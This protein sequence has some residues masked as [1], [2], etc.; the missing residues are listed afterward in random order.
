[1]PAHLDHEIGLD[2]LL[3]WRVIMSFAMDIGTRDSYG[4]ATGGKEPGRR[5]RV[6]C[7]HHSQRAASQRGHTYARSGSRDLPVHPRQLCAA[8][9]AAW[10]LLLLLSDK[11]VQGER[12][13][14]AAPVPERVLAR[15][16]R[17]AHVEVHV[18]SGGVDPR[19]YAVRKLV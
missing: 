2:W 9:V 15:T 6:L 17:E 12:D 8:Y 3:T 13:G 16:R 19:L 18:W 4:D 10:L 5:G 11:A 1:M 7:Y 14:K